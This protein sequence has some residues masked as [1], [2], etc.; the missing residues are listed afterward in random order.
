MTKLR[1]FTILEF[2][3]VSFLASGLLAAALPILQDVKNLAAEQLQLSDLLTREQLLYSLLANSIHV[4]GSFSCTVM[5]T[6]S[7]L[8][9]SGLS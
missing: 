9:I 6:T 1:G 2:L 3:L 5:P 4:A 7:A 8:V